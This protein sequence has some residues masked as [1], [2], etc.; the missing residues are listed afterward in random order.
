MLMDSNIGVGFY[1]F[2]SY[3]LLS[4]ITLHVIKKPTN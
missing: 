3:C 2:L 1:W 4:L